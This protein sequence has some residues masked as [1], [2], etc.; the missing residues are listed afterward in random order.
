MSTP[1]QDGVFGFNRPETPNSEFNALSFMIQ[2]M[3][4]QINVAT[5]V[6]VKAVHSNDT[7][8]A[9]TVDV[10]PMVNLVDG[11]GAS[12]SHTTVFGLPFFRLQGGNSGVICDPGVGDIGIALF[13]DH[14]ISS[15]KTTR[16]AATPNTA[17]RFSFS[18]GIY[19][20]GWGSAGPTQ[21]LRFGGGLNV[22]AP[23]AWFTGNVVPHNGASGSFTTPTG[24]MVTVEDGIIV[25]IY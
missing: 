24:Q 15:V 3:L 14:D 17:R 16:A 1:Q 11:T 13:C 20:G 6:K 12:W 23:S 22:A 2:S 10:V 4:N 19:L 9:G 21:Y 7:G 5:L 25:N 8:A 18:D